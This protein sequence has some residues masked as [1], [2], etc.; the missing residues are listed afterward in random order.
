MQGEIIRQKY[1]DRCLS[2]DR[3]RVRQVNAHSLNMMSCE[4]LSGEVS[5]PGRC[6]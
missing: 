6:V 5:R 4:L 2:S 1:C 3:G